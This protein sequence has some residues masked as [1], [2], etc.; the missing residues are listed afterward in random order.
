MNS[1]GQIRVKTATLGQPH[2]FVTPTMV[3]SSWKPSGSRGNQSLPRQLMAPELNDS[4]KQAKASILFNFSRLLGANTRLRDSRAAGPVQ[5][6][7]R[8]L[9][10]VLARFGQ[11]HLEVSSKQLVGCNFAQHVHILS[12]RQSGYSHASAGETLFD[13]AKG[14]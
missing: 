6:L 13:T 1:A 8:L 14:R 4:K 7:A 3:E 5:H 10:G 9:N 2:I 11:V 12:L